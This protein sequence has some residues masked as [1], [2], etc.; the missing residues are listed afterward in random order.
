MSE[1]QSPI[2]EILDTAIKNIK[3]LADVNTIVGAPIMTN[4]GTTVV[5]VSRLSVGFASGGSDFATKEQAARDKTS[6]GGGGGAGVSI[7]P[8]A[9]LL[10]TPLGDV[11]LLPVSEE[12]STGAKIL[13]LLP[14]LMAKA[15]DYF[16]EKQKKTD[17]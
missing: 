14:E 3:N 12:S 11:R 6:F 8:V 1:A 13:D 10:V 4:D 5:P 7:T 9:F 17:S 16:A 15:R 2:R